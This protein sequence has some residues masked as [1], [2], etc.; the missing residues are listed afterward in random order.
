MS[1]KI[2][3]EFLALT[4]CLSCIAG[5]KV[6]IDIK[7]IKNKIPL[8][9]GKGNKD[10]KLGRIKETTAAEQQ[11]TLCATSRTGTSKDWKKYSFSFTP[12]ASGLVS[13]YFRGPVVCD[14]TGKTL[15]V[16]VAYDNITVAGV[17]AKFGDFEYANKKDFFDGFK[18]NPANLVTDVKDAQSG[19]NYI[20]T[21][22]SSPVLQT[23]NVIK[24]KAVTISFYA[25]ESNGKLPQKTAGPSNNID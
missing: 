19:K 23:L 15:K 2:T 3:A 13:I 17:K 9:L 5:G 14:K 20:V 18:G 8:S 1:K 4:L 10:I 22:H 25:K 7:G 24:G 16:W 6:R 21:W 11:Y 12:Q